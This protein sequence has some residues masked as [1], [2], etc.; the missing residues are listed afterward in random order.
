[1]PQQSNQMGWLS[2]IQSSP[3]AAKAHLEL[4]LKILKSGCSVASLGSAKGIVELGTAGPYNLL[5]PGSDSQG[6]AARWG[7]GPVSL[8]RGSRNGVWR[9]WEELQRM[10]AA[11]SSCA[12][13]AHGTSSMQPR[14]PRGVESFQTT[15]CMA[16]GGRHIKQN[17][18]RLPLSRA[19]PG[20]GQ[21][22]RLQLLSPLR[23]QT[24][25][26][27]CALLLSG[28]R[29]HVAASNLLD[30]F[31]WRTGPLSLWAGLELFVSVSPEAR[32]TEIS[33]RI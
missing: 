11:P 5:F 24:R 12:S 20:P 27:R 2:S 31:H 1:M 26:L 19:A 17:R 13:P 18:L 32:W 25:V 28:P 7:L 6:H 30:P 21:S 16:T 29:P 33:L 4:C 14:S 22:P 23:A 8:W 10:T 3:Q 15:F 9:R